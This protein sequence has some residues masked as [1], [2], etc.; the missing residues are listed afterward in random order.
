MVQ[1]TIQQLRNDKN[2][3]ATASGTDEAANA[4]MMKRQM[5]VRAKKS[6]AEQF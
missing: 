5:T 4:K 3:P 2:A 1:E 6:R